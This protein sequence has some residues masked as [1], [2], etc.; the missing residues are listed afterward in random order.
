MVEEQKTYKAAA[1]GG[2]NDSFANKLKEIVI[3]NDQEI[4]RE[5]KS[6]FAQKGWH[7]NISKAKRSRNAVTPF[8]MPSVKKGTDEEILKRRG[9]RSNETKTKKAE[10]KSIR[11]YEV[12]Y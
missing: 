1:T 7:S 5:R 4:N 6:R 8:I 3:D 11:S 2:R 10:G 9:E 12:A